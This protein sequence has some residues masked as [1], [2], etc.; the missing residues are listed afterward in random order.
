MGALPYSGSSPATRGGPSIRVHYP[1]R[2]GL[3]PGYAG[4]THWLA[5]PGGSTGAHPRL[6]GEDTR[7][8]PHQPLVAGSSPATRGGRGH[9]GGGQH[10]VGLIPGYAGRTIA[11]TARRPRWRAH[12]RLR[13]EDM[14][15]SWNPAD[16]WGSSPA[17]RGGRSQTV[18]NLAQLGLIPGY[19]GRTVHRTAGR[20]GGWAHPRL[21]GED[22]CTVTTLAGAS[23]SSPATRGGQDPGERDHRQLGLIPGYAGRTA[24]VWL[25]ATPARAHPRLRGEDG[26]GGHGVFSF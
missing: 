23:G 12:P 14:M 3:I 8:V 25:P 26:T 21:R 6:R 1:L 9:R 17:T 4:R 15:S 11:G 20:T 24:G 18:G 5:G 19:A 7:P 10:D 2:S 16:S 13:G 22:P